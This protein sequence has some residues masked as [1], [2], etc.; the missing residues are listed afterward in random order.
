M[1]NNNENINTLRNLT[2]E[3]HARAENTMFMRLAMA[4]AISEEEYMDY[5]TQLSVIYTALEFAAQKFGILQEFPGISRLNNIR[6]DVAELN[7]KLGRQS[8]IVWATNSYYNR[9]VE[10]TDKDTV[11]AHFYVR[12][13]ADLYGGQMLKNLP[14]G[15]RQLYE[16]GDNLPF[17]RQKMREIAT[18]NLADQA[19]MAFDSNIRILNE[20]MGITGDLF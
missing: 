19:N 6:A 10:M 1:N 8:H 4:S 13:A 3:N 16:F 14:Y 2:A 17:L 20:V 12:Y 5:I 11:L 15:S 9:I 7:A 18:P